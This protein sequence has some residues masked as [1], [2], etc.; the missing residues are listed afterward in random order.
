MGLAHERVA[1]V[2]VGLLSAPSLSA[3][4]AWRGPQLC[5]AGYF[6]QAC[7]PR[8][9]ACRYCKLTDRGRPVRQEVLAPCSRVAHATAPA[10]GAR[11]RHAQAAR[12]P[13]RQQ[14]P[15]SSA[16]ARLSDR[17]R[18]HCRSAWG[19]RTGVTPSQFALNQAASESR[20]KQKRAPDEPASTADAAGRDQYLGWGIVCRTAC[21]IAAVERAGRVRTARPA[22]RE[23]GR[24]EP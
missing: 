10:I 20:R 13:Q 23:R 24:I 18:G 15:R 21:E 9:R 19:G 8:E 1:G 16:G 4:I 17:V 12:C 7:T 22:F 14:V 2:N 11:Q 3:G 5:C 6:G